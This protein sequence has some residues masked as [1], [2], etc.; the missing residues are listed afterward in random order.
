MKNRVLEFDLPGYL[1]IVVCALDII[2]DILDHIL[3]VAREGGCSEHRFLRLLSEGAARRY[4]VC[5]LEAGHIGCASCR[6]GLLR[7]DHRREVQ[8][9]QVLLLLGLGLVFRG[10]VASSFV[11]IQPRSHLVARVLWF[12]SLVTAVQLL[13]L[14]QH[15][16]I[17]INHFVSWS[18]V[19]PEVVN[20]LFITD[21]PRLLLL[22]C[23][24]QRVVSVVTELV[25]VLR[26]SLSY[27]QL[28]CIIINIL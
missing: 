26:L 14:S 5:V 13:R 21:L 12:V 4:L 19:L 18:L 23:L 20:L 11:L 16:G 27:N 24:G 1:L 8:T 3:C 9:S 10:I 17:S 2:V 6:G 25:K 7:V 28:G 15:I 22:V